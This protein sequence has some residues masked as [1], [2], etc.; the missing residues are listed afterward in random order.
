MRPRSHTGYRRLWRWALAVLLLVPLL[1]L[2]SVEALYRYG[3]SRVGELPRAP[4][5]RT[6]FATRVL[7]T[8]MEEGPLL[9]EPR[10]PWTLI[11]NFAHLYCHPRD[12]QQ[13][14]GSHLSSFVALRWLA[15]RPEQERTPMLNWHFH[16]LALSIWISRHWTAEE[17]M[18]AGAEGARFGRNLIGLD[19]AARRYFDKEPVQL[20][21]HEAAFLAALAQSP[22]RSNPVCRPETALRRRDF[23]LSHLRALGWI[24]DAQLEDARKQPLLP[25]EIMTKLRA[26]GGCWL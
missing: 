21:L 10:W 25:P 11:A 6:D 23:V 22:A 14:A 15:S 9:L 3:L 20:A 26:G 19:A 8:S 5:P 16:G 18:S 24:S 17:L 1:L 12:R 7:W 13:P 2:G 4:R